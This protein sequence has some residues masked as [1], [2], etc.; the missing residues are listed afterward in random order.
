MDDRLQA[1]DPGRGRRV[2]SRN[3]H[4]C[5]NPLAILRGARYRPSSLGKGPKSLFRSVALWLSC[6]VRRR[7]R[8]KQHGKGSPVRSRAGL[9]ASPTWVRPLVCAELDRSSRSQ[10]RFVFGRGKT[11]SFSI[12]SKYSDRAIRRLERPALRVTFNTPQSCYFWLLASVLKLKS[13][14]TACNAT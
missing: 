2:R 9:C 12:L 14:V 11:F 13:R 8:S 3:R 4:R 1:F 10:V 6:Q 7:K 5:V